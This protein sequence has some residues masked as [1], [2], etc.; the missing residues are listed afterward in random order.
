MLVGGDR[1][2]RRATAP[3]TIVNPATEEVVGQAPEASVDQVDGGRRG[4][5]RGVPGLEPHHARPSAAALLDRLADLLAPERRR[6]RAAGAGRDRRHPA[7]RQA[8]CRCPRRSTASAAT[9]AAPPSSSTHPAAAHRDALDRAGARR[10]AGHRRRAPR[11]SASWPASR[12]TTSRWSTWPARSARRWP[13]ATRSSSSRRRRTRWPS[14]RFADAVD[15]G[16]V[17]AGRG[18]RRHRQ[19]GRGR[20]G[21]RRLAA[22]RHGQLHRLDRASGQRIGEVAGRDMKR[23]LLELGG[24][25]AGRRVRR[26][27]PQA[28]RSAPSPACGR[29]HS[30][31]DL[32]RA[33]PGHRPAGHLRPARRRAARPPP[34]G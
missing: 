29:F 13:W 2:R 25:G 3:T 10:A 12:P 34:G 6:A 19:R 27:R 33:H 26:R 11:R 9:P 18:Q 16:R 24:K 7:G 21:A 28:P 23:L 31:P 17:P 5:G 1:V 4:G 22:R 20:R 8:P 15:R 32:H 14:L 30:G